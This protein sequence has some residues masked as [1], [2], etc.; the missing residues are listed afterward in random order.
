MLCMG[1]CEVYKQISI[2]WLKPQPP[3]CLEHLNFTAMQTWTESSFKVKVVSVL[4]I[5]QI[6]W[7]FMSAD[8]APRPLPPKMSTVK[9]MYRVASGSNWIKTLERGQNE[10]LWDILRIHHWKGFWSLAGQ[11]VE[12]TR[13][14]KRVASGLMG[15][16]PSTV[17]NQITKLGGS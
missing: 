14:N 10:M 1:G 4:F 5:Q 16:Q 7:I 6:E 17:F 2:G 13:G 3:S 12:P 15:F 11:S 8:S 9:P